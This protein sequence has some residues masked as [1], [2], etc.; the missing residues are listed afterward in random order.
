MT[1][2]DHFTGEL[3]RHLRADGFAARH[4][5][6]PDRTYAVT[7]T[8]ERGHVVTITHDGTTFAIRTIGVTGRQLGKT[9]RA[10][11][12]AEAAHDASR[13]ARAIRVEHI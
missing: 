10:N 11:T 5:Y 7:L 13:L 6:R 3:C 8:G 12:M 1:A 9:R 2:P 4:E